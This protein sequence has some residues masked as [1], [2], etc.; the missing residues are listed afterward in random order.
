[1]SHSGDL[2]V[3]AVTAAGPVGVDVELVGGNPIPHLL[4]SVCSSMEQAYVLTPKDFFTY[5]VR[6]EAILKATGE[7]M[8]R[9]MTDVVVTRPDSP[10]CLLSIE[11]GE[12]PMCSMTSITVDGYTGAVAVLAPRHIKFSFIDAGVSLLQV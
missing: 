12:T 5:W 1:V 7:G 4:T 9:E 2:V 8:R 11:G 6:K 10:P 3:V